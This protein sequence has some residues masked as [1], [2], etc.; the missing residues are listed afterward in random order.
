MIGSCLFVPYF[1]IGLLVAVTILSYWFWPLSNNSLRS[2]NV[3]GDK[4]EG[5]QARH[6][7]YFTAILLGGLLI[8]SA[9]FL[10]TNEEFELKEGDRCFT[11]SYIHFGFVLGG[12]LM[13]TH[14]IMLIIRCRHPQNPLA[15]PV[16]AGICSVFIFFMSMFLLAVV[17]S[18]A[19]R[20]KIDQAWDFITCVVTAIVTMLLVLLYRLHAICFYGR[21]EFYKSLTTAKSCPMCR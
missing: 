3:V 8:L 13:V 20:Q 9:W 14:I 18:T 4:G 21:D 5:L 2:Y 10:H 15:R 12:L 19:Y 16:H 11:D 17:I 7:I 1:F 6:V